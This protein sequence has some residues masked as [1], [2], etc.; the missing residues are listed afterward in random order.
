MKSKHI[1]VC[2]LILA[3]LIGII[4]L[5]KFLS[6]KPPEAPKSVGLGRDIDTGDVQKIR[7][8]IGSDEKEAME[9][10]KKNGAWVVRTRFDAPAQEQQI[11]TLLEEIRDASAEMRA[12]NAE[13]FGEFAIGDAEAVHLIL[14]GT[15]ATVL[16]HLLLGKESADGSGIFVRLQGQPKIYALNKNLR[17]ELRIHESAEEGTEIQIDPKG[18]LDFQPFRNL[19][20]EEVV[21][22]SLAS[23]GRH[24]VFE[25]KQVESQEV[26]KEGEKKTEPKT[27]WVLSQESTPALFRI[28]QD[29]VEQIIPQLK[30]AA[31]EDVIDPKKEKECGFESPTYTVTLRLKDGT[32]KTLIIGKLIDENKDERFAEIKGERLIWNWP[33]WATEGIFRDAKSLFELPPLV[34]DSA[35]LRAL[36]LCDPLKKLVIEKTGE[37]WSLTSPQIPFE[38]REKALD[39]F[40]R[41][42]NSATPDDIVN[43]KEKPDFTNADYAAELTLSD[44]TKQTLLAGAPVP[45]REKERYLSVPGREEIF[46]IKEQSL[47]S[48]FP[49]VT[50]LFAVKILECDRNKVQSIKLSRN[51]QE[52]N[53]RKT[54]KDESTY[55]CS[56]FGYEFSANTQPVQEILGYLINSV[57]LDVA[58][59]LSVEKS[60]LDSPDY[61]LAL[62]LTGAKELTLSVGKKTEKGYLA[63]TADSPLVFLIPER[64]VEPLSKPV[65][66]ILIMKLFEFTP[67][68]VQKLTLRTAGKEVLFERNDKGEWVASGESKAVKQEAVS[69]LLD[70]L[71]NLSAV[72]VVSPLPPAETGLEKPEK[73]ITIATKD[74]KI[75]NLTA[76]APVPDQKELVFAALEGKEGLLHISA[77]SIQKIFPE[78]ETLFT[79]ARSGPKQEK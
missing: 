54:G 7:F 20:D 79:D 77:S 13:L 3:F 5:Q 63:Q 50:S 71:S 75:C 14:Y 44:S 52:L 51:G 73:S 64:A 43:L 57:P 53:L 59:N 6:V 35:K 46:T 69:A 33:H 15:G 12:E 27:E 9:L 34:S 1:I 47:T 8:Y 36:T 48:V 30:N 19:K 55:K 70:A 42:F 72:D 62:K 65:S 61:I 49:T 60:G 31:A 66:E 76:G 2:A 16:Q 22:I 24:L 39:R 45:G 18:W 4:L 11:K 10:E 26:Q 74:G 29:G 58:D 38:P 67:Y 28:K 56:L 17:R 21:K 41:R 23:P 40:I 78:T 68:S 32:E 37:T 25:R